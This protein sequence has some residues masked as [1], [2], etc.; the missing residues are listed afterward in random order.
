MCLKL[1]K[2]IFWEFEGTK[3]NYGNPLKWNLQN[4][5]KCYFIIELQNRQPI[6]NVY[7]IMKNVYDMI[8]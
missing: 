5:I 8:K 4:A 3:D 6:K 2:N 1:N 7:D